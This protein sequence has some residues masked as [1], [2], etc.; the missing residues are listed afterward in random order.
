MQRGKRYWLFLDYDGTLAEFAPRPD[1]IL[2]DP[3]LIQIITRL[4]QHPDI[5]RVVVL[6]GRSLQQIT[7]LLPVSG[8]LLAGTYGVEFQ[9][10]SGE[11][12]QLVDFQAKNPLLDQVKEAWDD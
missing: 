3:Q 5:L 12:V 1:D 4:A 10:W 7:R 11:L 2:I 8:V 9:T 6:S